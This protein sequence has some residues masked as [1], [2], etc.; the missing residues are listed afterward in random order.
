M[1]L[2]FFSSDVN[3]YP[4]TTIFLEGSAILAK[5]PPKIKRKIKKIK[6][7]G[8]AYLSEQCTSLISV[9]HKY[10]FGLSENTKYSIKL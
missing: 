1:L 7:Q 8:N 2:A 10:S 9:L 4:I 5:N 3:T 6:I